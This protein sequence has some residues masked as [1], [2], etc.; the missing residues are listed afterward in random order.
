MKLRLSALMLLIPLTV[1]FA[2]CTKSSQ[3][4]DKKENDEVVQAGVV[5]GRMVDAQGNPIAG[6]KVYAGHTTYYNTNVLAV[7]DVNG[8]Y[9]LDIKNPGGTWTVHG[10]LQRQYNGQTYTFYVYAD[11]A[12]PVS[13]TAGAIRKLTWKLSGAIPGLSNGRYGAKVAYYDNSSIFIRDEEI[14]FTLI[15]EGPLVDGSTGQTITG[16]ATG[17]FNM[18]GTAVGSGLDDVPLGR[19][20]LSARYIPKNGGAPKKLSVRLR[21]VGTYTD[22]VTINFEEINLGLKLVEVETKLL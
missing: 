21:D 7:T 14:E 12:D 10:Q 13:G 18:I 22:K 1:I 8:Y 16:F 6:A 19:Y 4:D 17:R 3:E 15:P 2:N 20:Q 11:N 9:K 5:K